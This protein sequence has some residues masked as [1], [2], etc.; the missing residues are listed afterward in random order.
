MNYIE[1][2]LVN[3]NFT[4]HL[5]CLGVLLHLVD[6]V[7]EWCREGSLLV[8]GRVIRGDRKIQAHPIMVVAFPLRVVAFRLTME[9]HIATIFR[10]TT[11]WRKR[12]GTT[13]HSPYKQTKS[14]T[15]PKTLIN[16]ILSTINKLNE[17][18][19]QSIRFITQI[20]Q[21]LTFELATTTASH[22]QHDSKPS[23]PSSF[24]LFFSTTFP[25][26]ILCSLFPSQP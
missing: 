10:L 16:N 15:K 18:N 14:H 5:L 8:L 19:T 11:H 21:K 20:P 1:G 9:H 3:P 6:V 12:N 23:N 2:E 25:N 24:W 7:R 17:T 4:I 26:L 13:T 22:S